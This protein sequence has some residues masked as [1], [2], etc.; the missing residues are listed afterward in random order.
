MNIGNIGIVDAHH[1]IW[2]QRDVPWLADEPRPR[3]FGPYEKIRRD[4]LIEE[5]KRD[6]SAF[7]VVAST[8]AGQLGASRSLDEARWVSE[9][10]DA[11]MPN[12]PSVSD[13]CS[14]E[15]ALLDACEKLPRVVGPH[16]IHGTKRNYTMFRSPICTTTRIATG[17]KRAEPK[18]TLRSAALRANRAAKRFASLTLTFIL[19]HRHARSDDPSTVGWEG[20]TCGTRSGPNVL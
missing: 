20:R 1:H 19:N 2:H 17:S 4:Y 12:A 15:L 18:F 10:G 7:N 11:G 8:H 6:V 9:V 14:P 3:I 16:Q 5:F 13:L